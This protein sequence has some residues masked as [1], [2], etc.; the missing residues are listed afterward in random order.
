MAGVKVKDLSDYTKMLNNLG[1]LAETNR[2]CKTALFD[3]AAIIADAVRAEIEALPVDNK[4]YGTPDHPISTVTGA[5]KAGLLHGFGLAPMKDDR[6]KWTTQA[7][8]DGYNVVR[9]RAY[10]SGQANAMIASGVENG[11]SWRKPNHFI[12][13]AKRKVLEKANAAMAAAAENT[14]RQIMEESK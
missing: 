2:V 12:T 10:P 14:I 8:W 6:L 5:E 9:T 3:G 4:A 13:R 11:T 1:G 7:G